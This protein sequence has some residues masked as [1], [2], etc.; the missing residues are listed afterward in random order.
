MPVVAWPIPFVRFPINLPD[1]LRLLGS[2]PPLAFISTNSLFKSPNAFLEISPKPGIFSN[3]LDKKLAPLVALCDSFKRLF[4]F[5]SSSVFNLEATYCFCI[6]PNFS[7][8]LSILASRCFSWSCRFFNS[9]SSIACPCEA[10]FI[11][12]SI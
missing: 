1:D 10:N 4:C 2:L 11:C 5:S 6:N 8:S 3:M 12:C 7:N 9:F